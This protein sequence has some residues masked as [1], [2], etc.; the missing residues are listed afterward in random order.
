M[1]LLIINNLASGLGEGAIYD[2]V[3]ALTKDGDEVVIRSSDGTSDIRPFLHDADQF[4]AVVASGG[5]GTVATVSYA[6][7]YS[8]VPVLPFPAGTANLLALN[9]QSPTEPHALAKLIREGK[10]LDFDLGEIEIEGDRY[11]FGLIAGAGYDAAIMSTAQPAKRF[12]GQVAYFQAAIANAI[13]QKSHLK[14]T[15]DGVTHESDGL[16]V[17]GIN[18]SKMQFDLS[19]LHGN[20]PRD[21]LLD[22]CVLK[23]E[24]AFGL[25]PALGAAILDR[26]GKF[27]ARSDAL[28]FYQGTCVT[29]V[30][31]PP[32]EI[33]FDGEVTHRFTP[34]TM[35]VLP[36]A[37]RII[38]S[39]DGYELFS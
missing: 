32:M 1:K 31:D 29:V 16:G 36:G 10:T 21:G 20:F 15:V 7:A 6:L 11:G 33:Q 18:F 30:A 23:A 27:P 2:F 34:L 17:L 9:L 3:R 26:D 39:N 12:L 19:V 35:R 4:D 28:E 8:G 38:V 14:I 25:L 37:A 13:P 22:V 5:D 24:N